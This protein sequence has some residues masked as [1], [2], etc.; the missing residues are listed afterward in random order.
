MPEENDL[1]NTNYKE[2]LQN[3]KKNNSQME[4]TDVDDLR[5]LKVSRK[6]IGFITSG[7]FSFARSK[8][9][10]IGYILADFQS[11]IGKK[12][13]FRNPTSQFYHICKLNKLKF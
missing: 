3:R 9:Y 5:L 13:L 10:G 11:F 6:I 7:G 2:P 8:G 12:I 4:L 1:V